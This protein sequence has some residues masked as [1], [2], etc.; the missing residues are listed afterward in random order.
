M[1]DAA[2]VTP[3]KQPVT[4]DK[5]PVTPDKQLY[6]FFGI[7][8]VLERLDALERKIDRLTDLVQG[9][10][11][12]QAQPSDSVESR[13]DLPDGG[14]RGVENRVAHVEERIDGLERRLGAR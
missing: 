2:P 10:P 4:P 1:A 11:A 5:Q 9:T 7:T 6:D 12:G 8:A 3:D 13:M 14:I